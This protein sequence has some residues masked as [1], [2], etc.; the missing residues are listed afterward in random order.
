MGEQAS[1]GRRENDAERTGGRDRSPARRRD[2]VDP[3]L[4]G[5]PYDP[6]PDVAA[7]AERYGIDVSRRTAGRLQRLEAEFGSE[8]VSRWAEEGI[9]VEAMGKPRDMRAARERQGA[10]TDLPVQAK[11]EVSSPDDPAEREAERVA[12]RVLEMDDPDGESP[13]GG[14]GSGASTGERVTPVESVSRAP[15]GRSLPE[16]RAS[17]VRDGVR[18]GGKPLP[19]DARSGFEARFGADFSDVRVHTGPAADE[20]T[21][22]INAAAFTLGT[23]IAFADGKYNPGSNEGDEILAHELTHVVQQGDAASREQSELR[24]QKLSESELES[25][26]MDPEGVSDEVADFLG[27]CSDIETIVGLGIDLAEIGGRIAQG[28]TTHTIGSIAAP[29]SVLIAGLMSWADALA[30]QQQWGAAQGT[31]YAMVSLANRREPPGPHDQLGADGKAGWQA[32]A[33]RVVSSLNA[34]TDEQIRQLATM[35]SLADEDPQTALNRIYHDMVEEQLQDYFLGLIPA[36]GN[37]YNIAKDSLLMW[38]GPGI[39]MGV[40]EERVQEILAGGGQDESE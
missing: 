14:A 40:D 27:F 11:L 16:E 13:A 39:V 3:D 19:R 36:G 29:I 21:R 34:S 5:T 23:D 25:I 2:E 4:E 22:S 8:R 9:P 32:A 12:E 6:G 33:N 31:A 17:T 37:L 18:G 1:R 30:A 35:R 26:G 10:T 20:A 28:G 7:L 38:P 24:R 15:D